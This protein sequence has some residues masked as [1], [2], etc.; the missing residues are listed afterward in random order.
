MSSTSDSTGDSLSEDESVTERETLRGRIEV[1][2]EDNRRLRNEYLRARQAQYRRA[3]IGM[4]AVGFVAV[5]GAALLPDVR[6]TLLV[7]AGTGGFGSVLLFFLTPD[8][9]VPVS[10][11]QA[12][13][14]AY[15]RH[16]RHLVDELGLQD[17]TVYI[18]RTRDRET[19]TSTAVRLFVPQARDWQVPTETALASTFISPENEQQRGVSFE[20]TGA[21]L[22][23]EFT[24]A[25]DTVAQE[26]PALADQLCD[27]VV[28]QF[29]LAKRADTESDTTTNR[30]SV[31]I[32][33]SAYGAPSKFDH[34]LVSLIGVGLAS[35]LGV[36]VLVE[37]IESLE[38]DEYL[39]SYRYLD[40]GERYPTERT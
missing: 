16:V 36:P 8:S 10:V 17:T 31:R 6:T 19:D 4:A 22:V 23:D 14:T 18:P 15:E 38:S 25:V 29:E 13:Y 20:P 5:L 39:I 9:L 24:L 35:G 33:G 26:P 30:L 34:P 12:T 37:T 28:E 7:L 11:G 3:A 27:A 2:E 40:Q 32:S 21:S 1:L